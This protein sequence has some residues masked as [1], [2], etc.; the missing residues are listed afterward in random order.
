MEVPPPDARERREVSVGRPLNYL[1]VAENIKRRDH[2]SVT[3]FVRVAVVGL[4]ALCG[5][6]ADSLLRLGDGIRFA[7]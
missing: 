6:A 2:S 4:S 7:L 3:T 1:T 5:F